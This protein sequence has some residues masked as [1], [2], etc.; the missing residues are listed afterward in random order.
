MPPGIGAGLQIV[1]Y[2]GEPTGGWFPKPGEPGY[3]DR[4]AESARAAQEIADHRE[5]DIENIEVLSSAPIKDTL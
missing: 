4:T 2:L 1:I 5:R 3:V